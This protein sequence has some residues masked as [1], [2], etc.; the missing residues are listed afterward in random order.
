[1]AGVVAHSFGAGATAIAL[2]RGLQARRVALLGG[3]SSL[4]SV[5]ERWGRRHLLPEEEI[6]TFLHRVEQAV[7]EP[8]EDLD[9]TR[10]AAGLKIPSLIVHDRDDDE[11]PLEDGI[12]VARAWPGAKMLITE[13][14]GHRRIL[15]AR[16]VV[17]E[18]V[19]FLNDEPCRTSVR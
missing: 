3:P 19:A 18:V 5:V 12:A 9:V 14:H 10:I 7:G 11:I 1:L 6:P 2:A 16:Q 13:R 8:I 15:I 4:V 17:G